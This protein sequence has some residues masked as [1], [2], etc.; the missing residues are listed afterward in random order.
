MFKDD[1][2]EEGRERETEEYVSSDADSG[3][4]SDNSDHCPL[5]LAL[6]RARTTKMLPFFCVIH[7]IFYVIQGKNE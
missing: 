5:Q 3:D 7:V 4:D 6:K 2:H 1:H